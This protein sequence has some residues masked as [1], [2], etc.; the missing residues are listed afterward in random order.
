MYFLHTVAQQLNGQCP[1]IFEE[2][3][4]AWAFVNY[5]QRMAFNLARV[6][7]DR[8]RR[9]ICYSKCLKSGT[10]VYF[11]YNPDTLNCI[12]CLRRLV[13]FPDPKVG[14]T[15][16]DYD[17]TPRSISVR[18]GL[19]FDA[20]ACNFLNYGCASHWFGGQLG[21]GYNALAISNGARI[22]AL[23]FC[24]DVGMFGGFEFTI[25]GA[26]DQM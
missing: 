11:S 9:D 25:N 5:C 6:V 8:Y 2:R 18:T 24:T 10:C 4:N 3:S 15:L 7:P 1:A 14:S 21:G 13:R 19:Q 12:V 23:R 16:E 26:Q 17:S 22:T 20:S